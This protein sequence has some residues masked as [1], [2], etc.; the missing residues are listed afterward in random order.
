M[1]GEMDQDIAVPM[2]CGASPESELKPVISIST[3]LVLTDDAPGN[4]ILCAS[5]ETR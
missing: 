2:E 5:T 3:I 1:G 4:T